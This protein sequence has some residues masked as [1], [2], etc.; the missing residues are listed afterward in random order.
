VVLGLFSCVVLQHHGTLDGLCQGPG[1]PALVEGG[2][3]IAMIGADPYWLCDQC[4]N[5][6]PDSGIVVYT[7]SSLKGHC[8][9]PKIACSERCAEKI[10]RDLAPPVKR[11][12]WGEFLKGLGK[13]E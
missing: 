7:V 13:E 2:T 12:A 4:Y 6:L 1:S 9:Q 5:L 10:T 8:P 3:M 11:L